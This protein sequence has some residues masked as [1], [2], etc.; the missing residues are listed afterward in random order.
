MKAGRLWR[1]PSESLAVLAVAAG[2]T[3]L[4]IVAYAAADK[5]SAAE[6]KTEDQSEA[7]PAAVAGGA[8]KQDVPARL[9]FIDEQIKDAWEQASVKPSKVCTDEEFLRRVYLD[10]LGR[11]PNIE[12]AQAFLGSKESG[13]RAKLV[14]YLL[15][16]PDFAKNFATQWT[17]L[18]VGRGRQ[19]RGV[20]RGALTAWLRREF[21]DERPWHEMAYDLITAKGSSKENGATNFALSH[22][23]FGAVPLTSITTRVFLGQQIQCTQCHDHPSN[24]WK[25]ADFWGINAFFKGTHKEEIRKEDASGMRSSTTWN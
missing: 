3:G 15:E 4:G 14:N 11:I 6:S 5:P 13:K 2:L 18:L 21:K 19:E 16:Q 12:E 17:I 10:I 23:E 20:D 8:A 22:L 24:D 1:L 7:K 25:Q 9:D